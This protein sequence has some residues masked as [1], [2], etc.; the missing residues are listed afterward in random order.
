MSGAVNMDP[1]PFGPLTLI[2]DHRLRA[3]QPSLA[4]QIKQLNCFRHP[5]MRL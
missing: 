2:T 1:C 3:L 4:M 5:D